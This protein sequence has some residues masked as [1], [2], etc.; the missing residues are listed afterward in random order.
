MDT[1]TGT[2][3]ELNREAKKLRHERLFGHLPLWFR[4]FRK[5]YGRKSVFLEPKV[6]EKLQAKNASCPHKISKRLFWKLTACSLAF[7]LTQSVYPSYAFGDFS[8]DS[9]E[10]STLVLQEQSDFVSSTEDGFIFR[11][12]GQ[13]ELGNRDLMTSFTEY[14][15]QPGDSISSIA[16]R[17]HLNQNTV[18]YNNS[19]SGMKIKPGQKLVILPVDG[20]IHTV[21][22][23]DT[24]TKIAKK[25]KIKDGTT[26]VKQNDL[27]DGL[28]SAG[29]KL[30][31]PG[32]KIDIPRDY[33]AYNRGLTNRGNSNARYTGN[34]RP[35]GFIK[36][37]KGIYT[38]YFGP[39]HYAVDIA[40]RGKGPIFAAADGV[41]K[42]SASGWN[43]GYGNMIILTHSAKNA[44]TLYGH[45]SERYVKVGDSVKQGQI[46]GWMGNTGRVYGRTGIHLHFEVAI[47][48]R[49]RN[50]RAFF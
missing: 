7:F 30:I 3:L 38:K 10:G 28:I 15:V 29:Q 17:F 44:T 46:I 16:H 18:V 13:S 20:V 37:T 6:K 14:E 4:V 21:K 1:E 27:K 19:L 35:G 22:K 50:P 32:A 9:M 45:L 42:K 33:I 26:I 31:I 25:Y 5:L 2:R 24:L 12:A 47:D 43:G 8:H 40:N 36:P 39:G 41:V 48:G 49:K 34:I 23:N 11:I